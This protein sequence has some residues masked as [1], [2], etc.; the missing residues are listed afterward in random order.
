MSTNAST[1]E[2]AWVSEDWELTADQ[3]RPASM[4]VQLRRSI[5]VLPWFRFEYA[6]GNSEKVEL[7][8]GEH[9]VTVHGNRLHL[10]LTAVAQH[11]VIR[12]IQPTQSE[13]KFN[14]RGEPAISQNGRPVIHQILVD[15]N[16]Q[17]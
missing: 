3:H 13:A 10:L 4:I 14:V 11:R 9:T 12:L 15:D 7:Y 1:P 5:H 8:F 6:E 16:N 17:E 2:S